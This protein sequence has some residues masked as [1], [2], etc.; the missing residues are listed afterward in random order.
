MELARYHM[1]D[2]DERFDLLAEGRTD[3]YFDLLAEAHEER[4]C[5]AERIMAL[6]RKHGCV[7]IRKPHSSQWHMLHPSTRK[8]WLMQL[9]TWDV[10]GP[11]SHITV[12]GADSFDYLMTGE[13][14]VETED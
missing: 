3:E 6:A 10:L 14:I 13:I 8:P 9:T 12:T 4:I 5:A 11:V 7:R 1:A 2:R